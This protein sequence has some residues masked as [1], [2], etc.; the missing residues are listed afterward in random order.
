MTNRRRR[1]DYTQN[2]DL[3][4]DRLRR[5]Q[6]EDPNILTAY[7]PAGGRARSIPGDERFPYFKDI[8]DT[9]EPVRYLPIVELDGQNVVQNP[10][11]QVPPEA[12]FLNGPVID[13]SGYRLLTLF[14][15]YFGDGGQLVLVPEA[16][17]DLP[18]DSTANDPNQQFFPISVIDPTINP[19][20]P[21]NTP[22]ITCGG[23]RFAFATELRIDGTA[24]TPAASCRQI[25]VFDVNTYLDFRFR[26]GDTVATAGLNAFH[27]LQR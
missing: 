20:A 14:L 7:K 15:E 19:A 3:G 4:V 27:V 11:P 17:I 16:R 13:V 25:W 5:G 6:D 23:V 26:I 21:V 10:I 22:I 8:P 2:S 9:L 1:R 12:D 18:E 24:L